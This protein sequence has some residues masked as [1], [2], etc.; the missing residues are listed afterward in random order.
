MI[1]QKKKKAMGLK[2]VYRI[3]YNEDGSIQK[4]KAMIAAKG[5]DCC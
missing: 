2:W 4:H 5:Y 3:K 1:L